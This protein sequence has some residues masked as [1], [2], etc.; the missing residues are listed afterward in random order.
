MIQVGG[1]EASGNDNAIELSFKENSFTDARKLKE[2]T[3]PE[4]QPQVVEEEEEESFTLDESL[5]IVEPEPQI[6]TP[7]P[8]SSFDAEKGG[9]QKV[10]VG[11]L[12]LK[13]SSKLSVVPYPVLTVAS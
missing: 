10:N 5:Q 2:T 4:A 12:S 1:G 11:R 8:D 6:V 3:I 9:Q 7:A 13:K